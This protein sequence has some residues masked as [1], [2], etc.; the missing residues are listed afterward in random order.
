MFRA[1]KQPISGFQPIHTYEQTRAPS[2]VQPPPPPPHLRA[3]QTAS[4]PQVARPDPGP[5]RL[6]GSTVR[7]AL[8]CWAHQQRPPL[9][10]QARHLLRLRLERFPLAR[11]EIRGQLVQPPLQALAGG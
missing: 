2:E 8:T 9:R 4:Y 5:A 3:L 7:T 6:Y 11:L 10:P 1:N